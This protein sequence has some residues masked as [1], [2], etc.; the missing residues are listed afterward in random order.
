MCLRRAELVDMAP[1][2]SP[3][4]DPK[5]SFRDRLAQIPDLERPERPSQTT[6]P[7]E[8][9]WQHAAPPVVRQAPPV[10]H[11]APQHQ[12]V[13]QQQVQQHVAAPVHQGAPQN[14]A[15][16]VGQ[17]AR[18]RQDFEAIGSR[19]RRRW[20][21]VL[22][23]LAV[24]AVLLLVVPLFLARR[25]FDSVPRV[26]VAEALTAPESVERNILLVG[27]DSREGI[28]GSTENAD[29]I[30]GEGIA[31]ERSD[32]IMILR[33]EETGSRFLSL[34]RDLW[35]PINGGPEQRIN[36]AIGQGP[37]ALINTVQSELGI[38]I[39]N[40]VQVDLAGF[41]EV[42]DAVGGVDIT[43]E[44]PAF[45]R[46]SGLDLPQAGVVTLDSTQA[47]AWVRSRTYTEI[48]DGQQV[49]DPTSDLGRVAR[50]Q[51]FMRALLDKLLDQRNPLVL[52]DLAGEL[53]EALTV[54]DSTSLTEATAI[55]NTLR[56]GSPESVVLP[57]LPDT[58]DGNSVLVLTDGAPEVLRTFGAE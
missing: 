52:N 46:N 31:G 48:I 30:L 51:V 9:D 33:V 12:H 53:S 55:A 45:D 35:L 19:K 10:A 57:T 5:P 15:G 42:V 7:D 26:P 43:I 1:T 20:P 39:S 4:D 40:Y 14:A 44:N 17:P 50:Q 37:E 29:V 25:T 27:T 6:R 16:H 34:P 28:D 2:N 54:D 13:P 47:L 32:T 23:L 41:I 22:G 58:R 36:T 18:E 24:I 56:S 8:I 11:P 49:V 3:N 38:P 21:V